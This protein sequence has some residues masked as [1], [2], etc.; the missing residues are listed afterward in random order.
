[1]GDV[2][3]LRVGSSWSTHTLLKTSW[4]PPPLHDGQG[5]DLSLNVYGGKIMSLKILCSTYIVR[6]PLGGMSLHH[7]Q[8]LLGLERLGHEVTF[9]EDYGW[10]G[11]CYDPVADIVTSDPSCG[12]AYLQ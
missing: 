5:Q 10:S 8:Y 9:F 4:S 3:G 1:M 6:C 2:K 12:V 11:S 7:F